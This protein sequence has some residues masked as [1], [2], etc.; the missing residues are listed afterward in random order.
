MGIEPYL[1]RSGILAI[2]SQRLVRKLCECCKET[3]E[4]EQFLGLPVSK[5]RVAVGCDKCAGTGYRGRTVIAE[6]LEPEQS[7]MGRGILERN[8]SASLERLAREAGM[9][10]QFDRACHAVEE[11]LTSPEELIRIFGAAKQ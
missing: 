6:M 1:L 3:T 7:E 11:G 8:D 5:A 2:L 4:R 9:V 10:T